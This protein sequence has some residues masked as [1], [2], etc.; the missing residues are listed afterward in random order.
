MK[1]IMLSN[2]TFFLVR[3]LSLGVCFVQVVIGVPNAVQRLSIL[4]AHTRSLKLAHEVDLAHLAEMALGYVGAD[5][6][7]LCREAA[8]VALKRMINHSSNGNLDSSSM[9]GTLTGN[10]GVVKSWVVKK[11][12]LMCMGENKSKL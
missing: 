3:S 6:A 1:S 12:L 11:I 8:F 2:V 7:S 9:Q 4:E 10:E 5:I